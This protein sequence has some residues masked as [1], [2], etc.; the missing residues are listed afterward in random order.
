VVKTKNLDMLI[1]DLKRT[2]ENLK[3]WKWKLSPNNVYSEYHQDNYLD[4]WSAIEE[5]RQVLSKFKPYLRWVLD[6]TL[7]M[8]RSW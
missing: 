6:A 3:K 5:S 1:Q 2:F 4:F 8:Y 7:K